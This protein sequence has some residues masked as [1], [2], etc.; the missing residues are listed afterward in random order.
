MK[1]IHINPLPILHQCFDS[2]ALASRSKVNQLQ[3]CNPQATGSTERQDQANMMEAIKYDHLN[4]LPLPHK[5]KH[6]QNGPKK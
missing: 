6:I 4:K 3:C 5:V 1:Q 2:I